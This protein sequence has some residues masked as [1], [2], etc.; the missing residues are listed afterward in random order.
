MGVA[1]GRLAFLGKCQTADRVSGLHAPRV[2]L[3]RALPSL[4]APPHLFLIDA[5]GRHSGHPEV[6]DLSH[7]V[8]CAIADT[9]AS[10]IIC[11]K[12]P[13]PTAHSALASWPTSVESEAA[14]RSEW[15]LQ[16]WGNNSCS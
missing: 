7:V 9:F 2:A 16:H 12:R 11:A 3:G 5:L 15:G 14:V 4:R 13:C 6:E 1:R 10:C 8:S